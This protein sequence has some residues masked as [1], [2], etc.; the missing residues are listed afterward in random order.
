MNPT[1]TACT[2]LLWL[3]PLLI[4]LFSVY[5]GSDTSGDVWNYHWYNAWAFLHHHLG[6]DLEPAGAHSYFNPYLDTFNY[7]LITRLHPWVDAFVIGTIHGLVIWPIYGI[8]RRIFDRAELSDSFVL[9]LSIL[10]LINPL[11]LGEVGLS[12]HD[13]MIALIVLTAFF[14]LV[15]A[16]DQPVREKYLAAAGAGALLGAA[17]GLKLTAATYSVTLLILTPILLGEHFLGRFKFFLVFGFVAAL[18]MAATTG[19]WDWQLYKLYGNPIFPFFNGIFHSPYAAPSSAATRD[20]FFF[21]EHGLKE[22]LYP[23]YFAH[24]IHLVESTP[25]NYTMYLAALAYISV[26]LFIVLRLLGVGAPVR[27]TRP[28][29]ALIVYIAV[30]YFVWLKL[31]GVSRYLIPTILLFPTAIFFCLGPLFRQPAMVGHPAV[32]FFRSPRN[33]VLLLIACLCVY[34][35]KEGPATWGRGRLSYPYYSAD[36]IPAIK[37]A[38]VIVLQGYPVGWVIP[39]LNPDGHVVHAGPTLFHF[40]TQKYFDLAS[41]WIKDAMAKGKAPVLVF[42][43]SHH[44]PV[45]T[46]ETD[47]ALYG[48]TYNPAECKPF[49]IYMGEYT[50]FMEY[51]PTSLLNQP[52]K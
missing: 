2:I 33:W 34:D 5:M 48:L 19:M 47:I 31:F 7:I 8:T 46:I 20:M 1:R 37:N 50:G 45:S 24:N 10:C 18:G 52:G 41:N 13:N 12:L 39:P 3:F 15:H 17:A 27:M 29:L 44:D 30:S 25:T 42:D 23:F 16:V 4:G 11:F 36:H 32:A 40:E 14:A 22:L 51:C 6:R 21:R 38:D 26:P 9:L 49:H 35:M 28:R 43:S